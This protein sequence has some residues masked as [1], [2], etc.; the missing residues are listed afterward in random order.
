MNSDEQYVNSDFCLLQSKPMWGYYS[1]VG[2]KKKKTGK[3]GHRIQLNPNTHI[4]FSDFLKE[5]SWTQI[6]VSLLYI[7]NEDLILPTQTSQGHCCVP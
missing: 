7:D 6:Y 5:A 3:R 4:A 1:R 2:K